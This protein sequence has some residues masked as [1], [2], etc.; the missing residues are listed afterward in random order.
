MKQFASKLS[1]Q[2][3]KRGLTIS[4]PKGRVFQNQRPLFLSWEA[5][6]R[7]SIILVTLFVGYIATLILPAERIFQSMPQSELWRAFLGF[8]C[9]T[10]LQQAITILTIVLFFCYGT[11]LPPNDIVASLLRHEQNIAIQ[12]ISL[13]GAPLVSWATSYAVARHL[14]AGVQLLGTAPTSLALTVAF[15]DF[16]E[17]A[18][19][20]C[21]DDE[22][23]GGSSVPASVS[24]SI[25]CAVVNCLLTNAIGTLSTPLWVAWQLQSDTVDE[26]SGDVSNVVASSGS[27]CWARAILSRQHAPP[28]PSLASLTYQVLCSHHC[29]RLYRSIGASPSRPRRDGDDPCF[30]RCCSL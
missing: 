21:G 2:N 4:S 25:G 9:S 1:S 11:Q 6:C 15:C 7:P 18:S 22:N 8:K 10:S 29:A 30:P 28:A 12:V 19:V 5:L 3:A 24:E 13:I 23:D 17:T 26:G 20:R 14:R 27:D 16:V